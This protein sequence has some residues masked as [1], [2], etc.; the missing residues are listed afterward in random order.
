MLQASGSALSWR[1]WD[2]P[3][4]V[5]WEGKGAIRQRRDTSDS[6][7]CRLFVVMAGLVPAIHVGP[8]AC[9]TT[10]MA[11]TSPIGAKIS[12]DTLVRPLP[13]SPSRKGRGFS[14]VEFPLPLR[15]G[16]RGRGGARRNAPGQRKRLILAPT[17]RARA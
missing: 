1:L 2:E 11:G 17:G 6:N 3:G 12:S 5:G 9:C 4:H 8:L 15:E 16:D 10:W 13:P 7:G 14:A